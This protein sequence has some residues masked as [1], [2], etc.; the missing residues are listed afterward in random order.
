[1]KVWPLVFS[2]TSSFLVIGILEDWGPRLIIYMADLGIDLSPQHSTRINY[3][4]HEA[5]AGNYGVLQEASFF[6][7]RPG[8]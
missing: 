8:Y 6:S 2:A 5:D 4:K 7:G 1:M 3:L